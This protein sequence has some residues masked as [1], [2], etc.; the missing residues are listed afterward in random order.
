MIISL[1]KINLNRFL[2][3]LE[4]FLK[5]YLLLIKFFHIKNILIKLTKISE[6]GYDSQT[7][8][9]LKFFAIKNARGTKIIKPLDKEIIWESFTF[10]VDAKNVDVTIFIP[11]K[12]HA[13]KYKTRP[14]LA[15]L[16]KIIFPSSL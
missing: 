11:M 6:N 4:I 2:Y 5:F 10:S 1:W 16:C 14:L 9:N 12:G 15:Y 13:K 3:I 8:F 7:P